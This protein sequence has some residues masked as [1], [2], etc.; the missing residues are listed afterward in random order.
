MVPHV[1][2]TLRVNGHARILAEPTLLAKFSAQNKPPQCLIEIT[3]QAVYFH[4]GRALLR[5]NL[6]QSQS[7]DQNKVPT[8]GQILE[9]L[10]QAEIDGS[11]YDQALP[12]RIR[13]TLY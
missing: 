4:C 7:D 9:A 2:E 3:V 10:T 11:A 8:P 1:G 5:S 6:W 13:D 12:Q